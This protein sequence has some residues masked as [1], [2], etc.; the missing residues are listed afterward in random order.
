MFK[1]YEGVKELVLVSVLE[2]NPEGLEHWGIN[3]DSEYFDEEMVI[4]QK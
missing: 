3:V 2:R 1:G 4:K